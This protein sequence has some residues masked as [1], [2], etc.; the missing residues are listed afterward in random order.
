MCRLYRG[1]I[2]VVS[3][4]VLEATR[5]GRSITLGQMEPVPAGGDDI[6][7]YVVASALEGPNGSPALGYSRAI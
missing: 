5:M 4:A 1:P 6:A 2:T 3:V 7:L